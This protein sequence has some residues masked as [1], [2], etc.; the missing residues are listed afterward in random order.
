MSSEALK[1][2]QHMIKTI[3][4]VNGTSIQEAVDKAQDGCG[5]DYKEK[6]F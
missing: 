3:I 4:V 1:R 6:R 2:I 5:Q